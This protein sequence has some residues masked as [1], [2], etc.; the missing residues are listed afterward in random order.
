MSYL[1]HPLFLPSC[2]II[3]G[4]LLGSISSAIIVSKLFGLKDPRTVG[5][6]NPG[7]TN[8][9]REGGKAPAIITLLGDALKGVLPVG[10]A[11]YL[12]QPDW[13][14]CLVLGVAF[15]G[16]LY[17]VFFGFRGGKGVATAIGGILAM[18]WQ[19][20]LLV[21]AIW[22]VMVAITRIS[23][24]GALSAAAAAPFITWWL[25]NSYYA[26]CIFWISVLLIYRHKRNI[27]N[28][29]KKAGA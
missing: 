5:S 23:A 17:P 21:I 29:W 19:V 16:H 6:H 18:S 4:Y 2:L 22:L 12:Q 1:I 8:V 20:G 14:V 25:M 11:V 24:V 28:L 26:F 10:G 27:Q 7:A 15:L 9:L 13:V 3:L